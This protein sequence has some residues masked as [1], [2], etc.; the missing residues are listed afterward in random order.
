MYAVVKT[1]EEANQL[2]DYIKAGYY[3]EVQGANF[4]QWTDVIPVKD[5]YA[6][7]IM[8]EWKDYPVP[9]FIVNGMLFVDNIDK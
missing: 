1:I 8:D 2:N 5:G 9:D 3:S 4:E 6:L 7:Q